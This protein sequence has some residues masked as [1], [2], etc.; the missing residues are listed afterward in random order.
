MQKEAGTGFWHWGDNDAFK[1]FYL[2]YPSSPSGIVCMTNSEA[3]LDLMQLLVTYFF[4]KRSVVGC[5]LVGEGISL[6]IKRLVGDCMLALVR[7]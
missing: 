1:C 3:G 5:A 4:W 7:D 6:E 2:F